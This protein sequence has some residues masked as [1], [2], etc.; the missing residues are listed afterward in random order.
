MTDTIFE[1]DPEASKPKETGEDSTPVKPAPGVLSSLVGEGKKFA[2]PEDLAK[3][4]QESDAYIEQLKSENA[5]LRTKLDQSANQSNAL[6]EL[7]TE[8]AELRNQKPKPSGDTSPSLTEDKIAELV[9][10]SVTSIER[11]R[12][13][14]ANIDSANGSVLKYFQGDESKAKEYVGLKARELDMPVSELRAMAEKSPTAFLKMIDLGETKKSQTGSTAL[15]PAGTK[16]NASSGNS[17][18]IDHLTPGTKPYFDALRKKDERAYW[19]P[20]IQNQI[21]EARKA[22]TYEV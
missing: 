19:Q 12:T 20:K 5:G 18:P 2:T 14:T 16:M 15:S 11:G 8:I 3:G 17:A 6:E 1:S 10:E 9:K 13:A 7:R 4:K 22:G 21:F